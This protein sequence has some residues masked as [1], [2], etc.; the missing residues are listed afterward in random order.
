MI[1]IGHLF[2]FYFRWVFVSFPFCLVS[3]FFLPIDTKTLAHFDLQEFNNISA[4]VEMKTLFSTKS[5][6][7]NLRRNIWFR[8]KILIDLD[9]NIW[10]KNCDHFNG[11]SFNTREIHSMAVTLVH[12][13]IFC[14]I[15]N[16]NQ[17]AFHAW[18]CIEGKSNPIF[19][20]PNRYYFQM[21]VWFKSIAIWDFSSNVLV[22]SQPEINSACMKFNEIVAVYFI[23]QVF[24]NYFDFFIDKLRHFY[25]LENE[26]YQNLNGL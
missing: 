3:L 10:Q 1:F 18:I 2:V 5:T 24:A 19:I 16:W 6:A 26:F 25:H 11:A 7:H 8:T 23:F 15:N 21:I 17:H 13:F 4:D 14:S 12:L 22:Q 9:K 20:P